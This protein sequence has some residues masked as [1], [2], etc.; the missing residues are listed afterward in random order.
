MSSTKKD[1]CIIDILKNGDGGIT[2]NRV[3]KIREEGVLSYK[4][5]NDICHGDEEVGY[6]I[7]LA[8]LVSLHVIQFQEDCRFIKGGK[9]EHPSTTGVSRG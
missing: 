8:K 2:G 1:K 9:I 6:R 7:L 4:T 5:A 3:S